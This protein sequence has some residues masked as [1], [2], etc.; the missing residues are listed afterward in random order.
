[1]NKYSIFRVFD[2]DILFVFCN[3]LCLDYILCNLYGGISWY[4]NGFVEFCNCFSCKICRRE[5]DGSI[6]FC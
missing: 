2:Y 3:S 5:E 4:L 1:M 6:I